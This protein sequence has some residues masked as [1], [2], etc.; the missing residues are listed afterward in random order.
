M[1]NTLKLLLIFF[2]F[3]SCDVSTIS[4]NETKDISKLKVTIYIQDGNKDEL[5]N[6]I[7]VNLT[8]GKKQIINKKITILL[9]GKPLKLFVRQGNYYDKHSSYSTDDLLRRESY[10]FEII[11]PDSTKYPLA[12]LK[13]SKR[14]DSAQFYI[15]KAFYENKN[16]RLA[17]KNINI[18]TTV[19]VWKIVQP[20]NNSKKHSAGSH[21]KE[22]IKETL[23]TK[24]GKYI[25][26][27]SFLEDSLTT[28]NYVK[29]RFTKQEIGLINP[30]L[31]VNSN[32]TYDY[33]IEESINIT[34]K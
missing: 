20:K 28:V 22:R 2:A 8:D 4:E 34:E 10:Y 21:A 17:W 30:K 24:N 19:E 6:K 14:S 25:I 27:S 23:N 29:V 32:I 31:M 26:P 9:N 3:I 11:L 1:N 16:I 13:P 12:F 7:K 15:P 33:I 5:L 18:P